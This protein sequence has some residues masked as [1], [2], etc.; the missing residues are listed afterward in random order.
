MVL[1]LGMSF[2]NAQ[3][4]LM[5]NGQTE[6]SG[7]QSKVELSLIGGESENRYSLL[8]KGDV[9][10]IES[11][12]E[13]VKGK[14]IDELRLSSC[15]LG[16][17][18]SKL[19]LP[20]QGVTRISFFECTFDDQFAPELKKPLDLYL[21]TVVKC[22]GNIRKCFDM[23]QLSKTI[24]VVVI[25][26][27]AL[28]PWMID[29]LANLPLLHSVSF[30]ECDVEQ[31]ALK[32]IAKVK[33]LRHVILEDCSIDDQSLKA[34]ARLTHLASI[35]LTSPSQAMECVVAMLDNP[36]LLVAKIKCNKSL[37][38]KFEMAG[39]RR[40]NLALTVKAIDN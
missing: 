22:G 37:V 30:A 21:V 3:T 26:R 31:M 12:S 27:C 7:V 10:S 39:S 18:A 1:L 6:S 17:H 25:G 36:E 24:E 15:K 20:L 38:E 13:L 32:N 11:I 40:T 14:Q 19:F 8:I 33:K 4:G 2:G 16:K 28:Q 23:I 29:S 34:V 9:P 5:P 35:S